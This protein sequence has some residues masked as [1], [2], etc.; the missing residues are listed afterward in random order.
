MSETKVITGG[1]RLVTGERTAI[2]VT[3]THERAVKIDRLVIQTSGLQTSFDAWPSDFKHDGIE[4]EGMPMK[5]MLLEPGETAIGHAL[6]AVRE[7]GL[8]HRT[9]RD[10]FVYVTF[11]CSLYEVA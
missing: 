9:L 6:S 10:R 8:D 7:L 11:L 3:N 4:F 1:G 2:S 5:D